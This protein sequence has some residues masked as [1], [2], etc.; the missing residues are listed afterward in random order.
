VSLTSNAA[1][2]YAAA[3]GRLTVGFELIMAGEVAARSDSSRDSTASE[4]IPLTYG[5]CDGGLDGHPAA[6]HSLTWLTLRQ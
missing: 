1:S 5:L 2:L 6:L 3:P 4:I